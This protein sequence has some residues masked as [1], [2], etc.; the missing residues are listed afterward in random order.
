MEKRPFYRVLFKPY[1][2]ISPARYFPREG[3]SLRSFPHMPLNLRGVLGGVIGSPHGGVVWLILW[4]WY[5]T[6]KVD[7]DERIQWLGCLKQDMDSRE[8]S[9]T[10]TWHFITLA[11]FKSKLQLCNSQQLFDSFHNSAPYS[12]V[13]LLPM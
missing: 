7:T 11:S 13:N 10:L 6:R 3:S 9:N 4:S 5:A 8:A 2:G 1:F 12:G